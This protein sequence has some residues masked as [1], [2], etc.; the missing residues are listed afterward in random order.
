[1][2]IAITTDFL[3]TSESE[4]LSNLKWFSQLLLRPIVATVGVDN[5]SKFY[6]SDSKTSSSRE[7]FF[8]LIS[9]SFDLKQQ[10]PFDVEDITDEAILFVDELCKDFDL[11]VGYELSEQTRFILEKID[12]KYI[13]VWLHPI[14]YLDDVLFGIYS[15]DA[16]YYEHMQPYAVSEELFFIMAD[17][18]KVQNYK[19][20]TRFNYPLLP[21]SALFVGQTLL[22]KAVCYKGKFLN[23]LDFKD[24][25]KQIVSQYNYVYYSRHPFVK[26][27]DE[28][29]LKFLHRFDN[30]EIINQSSYKLLASE[31]IEFVFSVSS[32]LVSEA[33]YFGKKVRFLYK[34]VFSVF[35]EEV[36]YQPIMH[37]LFFEQFWKTVLL[38]KNDFSSYDLY[39][40][41]DCIRDH[42]AFYWGYRD[43]D[44]L[45]CLKKQV[46]VLSNKLK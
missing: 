10:L 16:T 30:V 40:G 44:K 25:F 38:G 36:K 37:A 6:L 21:Q 17:L 34:P 9:R 42:L 41:K 29:I 5:V 18:L 2:K 1:M 43:I 32:S 39:L 27:G 26:A 7:H 14:R 24:E 22:D 3:V 28:Q 15:N 23:L 46:G 4:Q 45:E 33:F 11:I 35:G 12:K 20:F 8:S 19:G 13:D 31:S